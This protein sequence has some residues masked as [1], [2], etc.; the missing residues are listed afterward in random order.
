M[1]GFGFASALTDLG[2]PPTRK[3]AALF[4][5]NIGVELG[6]LVV[7]ALILPVLFCLRR[8]HVYSRLAM[9][10]GSVAISIIGF[11]WFFQRATGMTIIFG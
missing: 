1:H 10:V 2:L 4:S 3:L 5:F 11:L 6:Q 9:P 8:T 7:V